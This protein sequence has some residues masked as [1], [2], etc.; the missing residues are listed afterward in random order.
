MIGI[1]N[2]SKILCVALSASALST[3]LCAGQE[4]AT[5]YAALSAQ[6]GAHEPDITSPSLSAAKIEQGPIIATVVGVDFGEMGVGLELRHLQHLWELLFPGKKFD[7]EQA[8]RILRKARASTPKGAYHDPV[9]LQTAFE[10]LLAA[11]HNSKTQVFTITWNRDIDD[12]EIAL[13]AVK[14]ELSRLSAVARRAQQP[15]YLVGHSW[16]SVLLYNALNEL[17]REGHTVQVEKFITMGSPIFPQN[18]WMKLFM[19]LETAKEKLQKALVRP[20]GV[21]LWVNFYARR[22]LISSP[23]ACADLNL[24]VDTLADEYEAQLKAL[25]SAQARK[26]LA[27]LRSAAIWHRAYY[28]DFGFSLDSIGQKPSWHLMQDNA[29]LLLPSARD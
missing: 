21:K 12:S 22:D 23:L 24:R 15:L 9:Y 7:A 4:T 6:S 1:I 25:G 20:P 19:W 14:A 8:R 27:K 26:E 10:K 3:S 13:K 16:G 17:A 11:N 29:D 28:T 18:A 2:L 5:A